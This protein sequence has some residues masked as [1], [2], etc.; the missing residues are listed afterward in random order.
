MGRSARVTIR[1]EPS[2]GGCAVFLDPRTV[3]G[4]VTLLTVAASLIPVVA[5]LVLLTV[6]RMRVDAEVRQH[7]DTDSRQNLATIAK[8]IYAICQM[9]DDGLR[10]HVRRDV[11]VAQ[12]FVRRAGGLA[13]SSGAADWE[14]V[15]QFDGERMHVKLPQCTLG[16]AWLGQ[17]R[18]RSTHT[19]LV[20]DVTKA[21]GATC[22]VFQ[23][24]NTRGD[25]LRVATNVLNQE[26]FR[27]V[28]TYIPATNP[29]GQ[30]NPVVAAILSGHPFVGRAFVVDRWY[31]A[32]YEPLRG[33]DGEIEGM[34]Y[35]GL[36]P[37][38]AITAVRNEIVKRKVG[39]SGYVYVIQGTGDNRGAYIISKDGARDGEN[40]WMAKDARDG[41]FI[42]KIV[43]ESVAAEAGEVTFQ[44][45]PWQNQNEKV[46]RDK[47]AACV[48]F[49]SWDWVIGAGAYMDELNAA[50]IMVGESL[51][52]LSLFSGI[53]GIVA[54]ASMLLVSL[55]LVTRFVRDPLRRLAQAA[56]RLAE[57]DV[58]V[59][60][61]SSGRDEIAGLS[62]SM[63]AM[64]G[65]AR[66]Q[67]ELAQSISAG[68]IDPEKARSYVRSEK[69]VLGC[70]LE[71]VVGALVEL[72]QETNR[73]TGAVVEGKL[74]TRGD[75]SRFQGGY[76]TIIEGVNITLDSLVGFLDVMPIP[77][78]VMD[79]DFGIRYAN[80]AAA[81]LTG[82]TQEQVVGAHCYDLFHAADCRTKECA[83]ARSM[84]ENRQ[85]TAQTVANPQAGRFEISYSGVPIRD[86]NGAV[87]GVMEIIS[88]Q[89]AVRQ[90]ERLARKQADYQAGEV[91]KVV[92]NLAKLAE[93]DLSVET[94]LA[95]ADADTQAIRANFEQIRHG[96]EETVQ[97]VG[98]LVSDAGAL[99]QAAV[100]GDLSK[101]ADAS[102]HRGSYARIIEG[103]NAT[104]DA[105]IVPLKEAS[106]VLE[107]VAGRD[108]TARMTGTYRGD[109]EQM[110]TSVCNA[111]ENLDHALRQVAVA[112][113]QVAAAA[114]QIGKGSQALAQGTSEQASSLEEVSSSLQELAAMTRQNAGNTQEARKLAE[115]ARSGANRGL[116]GMRRLSEAMTKIQSSSEA[117][118]KIVKTI[119]EIAFQTNL[120]ALNAAVEA[121]RAGDVGQGFAVVAEEVRS[122]AMRS[123]EAA[124]NTAD[125]IEE[126]VHNA[127]SGVE[128]NQTV[129]TQL[130]EITDQANK[131]EVVMAEIASGSEQQAGGIDQITAAVEQMNQLTQQN[132]ANSEESASAAEELSGQAEELRTM[133]GQFHLGQA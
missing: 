8:D 47:I 125:L 130:E 105:V 83:C 24:M 71:R 62:R 23:R 39:Q 34:L 7:I 77:V 128:L 44:I 97:A 99:A 56:D 110:K 81:G 43:T 55:G 67:A 26:G 61:D 133:L 115:H 114:Q 88:D 132:A 117:T 82:L 127:A 22:T 5:V 89:T 30:P 45:Y 108:M 33:P 12:D 46:P 93:G 76:R 21:T 98:N 1:A 78:V 102:R 27:G 79:R 36:L 63:H 122:L 84:Q 87:V 15:N 123:A 29:D 120:L 68:M 57:G 49:E 52:H 124:K 10:D 35:C 70:S 91:Q 131:V 58:E 111:A 50:A 25:M 64:A 126:S 92:E 116:D 113:R 90:S 48:Y 121:A 112:S 4:K 9:A 60:I 106:G 2:Q 100:A 65:A 14:A 59:T 3:R 69:D 129:H 73:L 40:I 51:R 13:M 38:K 28:G 6:D 119:D 75:G 11:A 54:C 66:R 37:E 74:G 17:N 107:R 32:A 95:E 101:R 86:T 103:V 85:V 31:M 94:C 96:L 104:L 41:L 19:A 118:A 72:M 109:L 42:Q 53:A 20:D 18:D 16:G 80:R